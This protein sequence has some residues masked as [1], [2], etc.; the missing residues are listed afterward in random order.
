MYE[1]ERSLSTPGL[2]LFR[3]SGPDRQR[4][5]CQTAP[6][7]LDSHRRRSRWPFWKTTSLPP[8]VSDSVSRRRSSL[9][10]SSLTI[11]AAL[12]DQPE[13]FALRLARPAATAAAAT[14]CF[15]HR[16]RHRSVDGTSSNTMQQVC[17]DPPRAAIRRRAP[18]MR[19]QLAPAPPSPCT[20]ARHLA[21]QR[22]LRLRALAVAS[23][24][25]RLERGDL[26]RSSQ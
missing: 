23:D 14:A 12:L 22:L 10:R 15:E 6:A 11:D 2:K 3:N 17:A 18:P 19:A 16:A 8:I 20:I 25:V 7:L 1:T 21:R 24:S 5:P 13:R 26:A 9:T 4:L